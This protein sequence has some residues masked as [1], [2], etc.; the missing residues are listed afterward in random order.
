M[1]FQIYHAYMYGCIHVWVTHGTGGTCARPRVAPRAYV[2]EELTRMLLAEI[3]AKLGQ[4][5]KATYE[6]EKKR[7]AE[8]E[9]THR[10]AQRAPPPRR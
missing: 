9:N 2:F 4:M 3:E 6:A 8:R 10:R 1:A 7:G 5:I